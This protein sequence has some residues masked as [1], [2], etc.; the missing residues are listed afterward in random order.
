MALTIVRVVVNRIAITVKKSKITTG[1]VTTWTALTPAIPVKV[2][3][4]MMNL[5]VATDASMMRKVEKNRKPDFDPM[6]CLN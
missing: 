6:K 1:T 2:T 4:K 5:A 3:R